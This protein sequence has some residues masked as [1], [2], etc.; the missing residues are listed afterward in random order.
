MRRVKTNRS[1]PP[2]L[3]SFYLRSLRTTVSSV[4]QEIDFKTVKLADEMSGNCVYEE[5]G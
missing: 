1:L 5:Y 2:V 4:R 3:L